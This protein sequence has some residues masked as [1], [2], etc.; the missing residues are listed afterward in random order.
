M[1]L[2]T[3]LINLRSKTRPRNKSFHF[4]V[5]NLVKTLVLGVNL[6]KTLT[7][8]IAVNAMSSTNQSYNRYD[9]RIFPNENDH[10]R[11]NFPEGESTNIL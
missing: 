10:T 1:T 6:V 8:V 4:V 5:V 9:V 3:S 7:W 2:P 11:T